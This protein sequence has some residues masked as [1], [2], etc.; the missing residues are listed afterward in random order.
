MNSALTSDPWIGRLIGEQQRYRLD[1]R[2]GMGGMGHVF[3][4][5]DTRLGKQVALKLLK[6][7]LAAADI[8]RKRF[9]REVAVCAALKSDRIVQINDYGVTAQGHPFYVMEYLQGQT[10]GQLLRREKRLGVE[11]TIGI[12]TQVCEGLRLAHEGVTLWRDGGTVCEHVKVFHRDLKP[13]N[14]FLVPTNIG[15]MV[16]ILDFGIAK[17]CHDSD[18]N[19]NLTSIFLGTYHYAAPEQLEVDKDLDGRADIYN[20]GIIL[21]EMLSGTDPFGF[22]LNARNISAMK[23]ALAHTSKQPQP[24]LQL[25]LEQVSPELEAVVMRCLQK[26]PDERFAS[27]DELKRALQ[28]AVAVPQ[29]PIPPPRKFPLLLTGAGIAITITATALA[30][31]YGRWQPTS[32]T[33]TLDQIRALQAEAKYPECITK[34][35]TFNRS[36]SLY[37]K[38]KEILNQCQLEQAKKLAAEN[39]APSDSAA[40]PDHTQ[41]PSEAPESSG[42]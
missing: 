27:V 21:Y 37:V 14:I 8:Y 11:Q 38:A 2:L 23:W 41:H 10:L 31:T 34:A 33:A 40:P 36:S 29:P 16:K 7:P 15:D 26:S 39:G 32:E 13:D 18:A 5:M 25:G 42:I 30:Y 6:E 24:L 17:I 20:L 28:A 9:E 19:T 4:A 35:K 1:Q 12:I 22:G 3:V